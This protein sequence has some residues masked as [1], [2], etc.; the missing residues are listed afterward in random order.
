MLKVMAVTTSVKTKLAIINVMS[1]RLVDPRAQMEHIMGLF[2]YA[3]EKTAVEEALKARIT[4]LNGQSFR[5]SSTT[6]APVRPAGGRGRGAGRGDGFRPSR[7]QSTTSIETEDKKE[8]AP[9]APRPAVNLRAA[10]GGGGGGLGLLSKLGKK[11]AA[12]EAKPP[13]AAEENN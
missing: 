9:A 3:D 10:F 8:D 6:A 11:P 1:H 5:T 13:Q 7:G 4:V 2:R 12:E